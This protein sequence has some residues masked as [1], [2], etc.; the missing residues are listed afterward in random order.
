MTASGATNYSWLP[1]PFTTTVVV[2]NPTSTTTYTVTGINGLCSSNKTITIN[3]SS[4]PTVATS[5][6]NTTICNGN[7]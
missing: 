2:V 6:T 4:T 7:R 1:G 3:V 5:I